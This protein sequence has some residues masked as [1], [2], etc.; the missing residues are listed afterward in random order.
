M[1]ALPYEVWRDVKDYEGLYQV[2]NLG[3]VKRITPTIII[4]KY[5]QIIIRN[6]IGALSPVIIK[7]YN[8]VVLYKN[9]KRKNYFVHRLVAEAFIPNPNNKPHI[10]HIDTH[11]DNNCVW[12]L[13]WVTPK[14]NQNNPLTLK[15]IKKG[16]IGIPRPKGKGNKRSIIILQYTKDGQFVAEYTGINQASIATGISRGNIIAVLKGRRNI[17]GGYIWKYT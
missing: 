5:G 8:R 12:N 13:K 10:D 1:L 11:K 15:H 14:E 9:C 6:D 17:A 3:N 7:G 2:S 4:G 16:L